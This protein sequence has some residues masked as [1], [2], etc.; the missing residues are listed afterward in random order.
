METFD[1]FFSFSKEGKRKRPRNESC[2]MQLCEISLLEKGSLWHGAFPWE[3]GMREYRKSDPVSLSPV[4]R[5]GKMKT[6]S[7]NG[8][9]V[10]CSQCLMLHI[11]VLG[12]SIEQISCC[13]SPGSIGSSRIDESKHPFPGLHA[14]GNI[15]LLQTALLPCAQDK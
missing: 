7:P 1:I 2:Q 6:T 8:Y 12:Q 5:K 15:T 3:V 4:G 9:A 11:P 14:S 10:I 13:T